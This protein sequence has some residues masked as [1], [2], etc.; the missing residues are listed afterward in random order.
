MSAD[1]PRRPPPA[2]VEVPAPTAW[3]FVT[4]AGVTLGFAGLVTYLA[5]SLVGMGLALLGLV[6]WM[7]ELFPRERMEAIPLR[8]P[9]LRARPASTSRRSI[10][11]LQLGER[12]HRMRLPLE[13]HP[14]TAGVKAG[15]A[16]GAAMAG[17]ALLFGVLVQR[18][19]WYPIN[20]LAAAGMPSLAAGD[21][22]E[23]RALNVTALAV[24]IVVHG[25]LSVLVGLLYAV[26]LPTLPR[27]PALWAGLVAPLLWT[28]L[29]WSTLG[30]V[31][32]VL[33]ARI[34]WPWFIASQIAFGLVAGWVIART[35]PIKTMQ[36][37]PLVA[38][39]RIEVSEARDEG[40]R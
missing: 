18:S 30:L 32:P 9:A 31:N 12:A 20:L 35:E 29:V 1:D 11:H 3:P 21:L 2:S 6:G 33:N 24:G 14:Y 25:V 19:P 4:A 40:D 8:A 10:E 36:A 38:R 22:A 23:L 17:V 27:H 39:A 16:G 26:I 15:L 37:W 13:I 28:A 5:V 34:E 7:R